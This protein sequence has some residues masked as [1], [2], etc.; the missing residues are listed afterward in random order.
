M[1][2]FYT[3]NGKFG[4]L[5]IKIRKYGNTEKTNEMSKKNEKTQKLKTKK[6]RTKTKKENG[7]K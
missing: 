7:K 6:K 5:K 3:N 2:I 1:V 4:I